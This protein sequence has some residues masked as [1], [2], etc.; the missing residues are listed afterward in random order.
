[1]TDSVRREAGRW[2]VGLARAGFAAK[3]VVYILIG[4]LAAGTA[5]GGTG[6]TPGSSGAMDSIADT[7]WGRALLVAVAVGLAGY[8]VWRLVYAV[9]DP[10][11]RSAGQRIFAVF[12]GTVY[13]GLALEAAMIVWNGAAGGASP[14]GDAG[15][16]SAIHWTARLMAQPFGRWLVALV[17]LAVAGYGLRQLWRAWAAEVSDRLTLGLLGASARRWIV[18]VSRFGLGARGVVLCIIGA[19]LCLAA[20]RSRPEEARGLGGALEALRDQ[21]YGP[22]LLLLMAAGLVAYG[23]HNLVRARYRRIEPV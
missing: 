12:S 5:M 16:A 18:R 20:L 10:E 23:L 4:V 9:V 17:G 6:G 7:T 22:W 14:E 11:H 1:M 8:V 3:G 19:F 21:P 13:A 2:I 15:E